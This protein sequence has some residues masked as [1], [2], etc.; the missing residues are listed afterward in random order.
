MMNHRY[1]MHSQM[2]INK[3]VRMLLLREASTVPDQVGRKT[4]TGSSGR[5]LIQRLAKTSGLI[6]DK[7]SPT[8]ALDEKYSSKPPFRAHN[9]YVPT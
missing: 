2:E 1:L 5:F 7:G 9:Y 3:C 4:Y 8:L 6:N